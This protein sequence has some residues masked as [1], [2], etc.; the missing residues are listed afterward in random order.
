MQLL[1]F[2]FKCSDRHPTESAWRKMRPYW[3]ANKENPA[4]SRC[5]GSS[6]WLPTEPNGVGAGLPSSACGEQH[7]RSHI[8]QKWGHVAMYFVFFVFLG[9]MYIW[10]R[11]TS[12]PAPPAGREGHLR[13]LMPCRPLTRLISSNHSVTKC[14]W[15]LTDCPS[16]T[17]ALTERLIRID[18]KWI[19]RKIQQRKREISIYFYITLLQY[20]LI[21]KLSDYCS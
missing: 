18:R 9:F 1:T 20:F 4:Q 17:P 15:G 5:H 3:P 10:Q 8:P 16:F 7:P 6:E 11:R 12:P 21:A 13:S 14:L 2:Y 19:D